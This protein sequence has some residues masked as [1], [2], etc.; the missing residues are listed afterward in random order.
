M[1]FSILQS[2]I[3]GIPFKT[4]LEFASIHTSIHLTISQTS[5]KSSNKYIYRNTQIPSAERHPT[6]QNFAT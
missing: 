4:K 1:T 3:S 2:Q 6:T 5:A